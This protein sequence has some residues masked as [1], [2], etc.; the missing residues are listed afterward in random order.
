MCYACEPGSHLVAHAGLGLCLVQVLVEGLHCRGRLLVSA[1]NASP[2]ASET[3]DIGSLLANVHLQHI[4]VGI[5]QYICAS[6]LAI[7]LRV[8]RL[9]AC[10]VTSGFTFCGHTCL[11]ERGLGLKEAPSKQACAT[12]EVPEMSSREG[13]TLPT[14]PGP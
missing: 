3:L 10:R 1:A 9:L 2:N 14:S 6:C 13:C 11:R 7:L 12:E 5:L 4:I 8:S